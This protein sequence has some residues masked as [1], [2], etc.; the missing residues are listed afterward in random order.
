MII[1]K[2]KQLIQREFLER[3]H[4]QNLQKI[5]ERKVHGQLFLDDRDERINRHGYP[6]LR[7]HRVLRRSV[8][9]FDAEILLDPAEKQLDAPAEFIEFGYRQRR[10]KKVVGQKREI[11]I[12]LSIKIAN[13]PQR[14]GIINFRFGTGQD[15][16]LV[17]SQV[18]GFIHGSRQ[19]PPRLKIRLGSDDEKHAV[20]MKSIEPIEIQIAAI[21]DVKSSGLEG[22]LV[23]DSNIVRFPIRHMDKSRDRS[24][25]IEKGMEFDR[26]LALAKL[27]PGE[28]RQAQVDRCR[29]EGEDCFLEPQADI[30]VAVNSPGFGE[31]HLREIGIDPP[32][33]GF[34]G[35]GQVA[36]RDTA[37][38][39]HM[40]KPLL[41][42]QKA[43]LDIAE[44]FPVGQL[45]KSQ[46]KKLI[47]TEEALDFVIATVT[48]HAFS[49]FVHRQKGHD[50]SEDGRLGVHRA[51][52]GVRKSADYTKLRSNR[53]RTKSTVS[54][55]FRA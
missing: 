35:V 52:P 27:G 37:T 34:V 17:G 15:D 26:S 50:L 19:N 14:L 10:L 36:S 43:S 25:Q 4:A 39:A 30:F 40:V 32:I 55:V 54:S 7:P 23:E 45:G 5:V 47:E 13:P 49:E 2:R 21:H 9:R 33:A 29:I 20:L 11:A 8:K 3:S 1:R 24:S 31:E 51:L 44:A 42:G 46:A 12:I 6:D 53:S 22:Q 48:S 28:E 41:H 18:H 38:D 16:G